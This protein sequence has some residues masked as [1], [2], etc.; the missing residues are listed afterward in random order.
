M[1][2]VHVYWWPGMDCLSLLI[3]NSEKTLFHAYL[4]P[5]AKSVLISVHFLIFAASRTSCSE[6][7]PVGVFILS[8]VFGAMRG[9]NIWLFLALAVLFQVFL[10]YSANISE[11][12]FWSFLILCPDERV[13]FK[14]YNLF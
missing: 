9:D 2:Y 8:F 1:V 4:N 3:I 5:E 12:K 13:V 6:L 11:T 10:C 7:N 14:R